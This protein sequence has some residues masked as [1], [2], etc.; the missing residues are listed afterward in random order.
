[1][2]SLRG[3]RLVTAS[4]TEQGRAWA[5]SKI[6]SLTG[7]DPITARFM[8]QDNFTFRPT[9]KLLMAG[10]HRPV[11]GNVDEAARRR[12]NILPFTRQPVQRDLQLEEKLRSEWPGILRWI[13]GGALDWQ[14]NGLL[15]PAAVLSE[16]EAYFEAQD[17]FG[18]WLDEACVTDLGNPHRWETAADLYASWRKFAEAG[19]ENAGTQKVFGDRLSTRG[20]LSCRPYVGRKRVRSWSGLSFAKREQGYD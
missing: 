16:T 15:R 13:I 4:E 17:S 6:K 14:P 2:A 9:F 5:E 8:R 1:V 11:L 3:A 20:Y 12:F 7:G 10:N 19:G 18:H